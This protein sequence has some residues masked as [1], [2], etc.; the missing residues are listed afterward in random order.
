MTSNG[1]I[2][3]YHITKGTACST[4]SVHACD[5]II[6][7]PHRFSIANYA[8]KSRKYTCINCTINE[9]TLKLGNIGSIEHQSKKRKKK[10][11]N[12][13]KCLMVANIGYS[14]RIFLFETLANFNRL[15]IYQSIHSRSPLIY[16]LLF[17]PT[18]VLSSKWRGIRHINSF[19]CHINS[20]RSQVNTS[21][22]M[23]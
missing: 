20:F 7:R 23:Y 14:C 19:W 10:R 5:I 1:A 18:L 3:C 17:F 15:S 13:C 21:I 6:M 2:A 22:K 9:T 8:S 11:R 12:D 16:L 4:S